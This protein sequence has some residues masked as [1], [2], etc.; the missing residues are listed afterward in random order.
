M[1]AK[2]TSRNYALR[3]LYHMSS[4]LIYNIW[5]YANLL[6]ARHVKKPFTRPLIKLGNLAAYFEAFILGRLGPPRR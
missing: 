4:V 1:E 2:T 6:L 3:F 5:Q